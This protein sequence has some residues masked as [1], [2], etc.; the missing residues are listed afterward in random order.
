MEFLHYKLPSL[1]VKDWYLMFPKDMLDT[2]GRASPGAFAQYSFGST[3]ISTLRTG[4]PFETCKHNHKQPIH[5]EVV[6][7]NEIFRQLKET[8]RQ[9]GYWK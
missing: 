8:H 1:I 6:W 3:I 2:L 5:T 4:F 9:T 7:T